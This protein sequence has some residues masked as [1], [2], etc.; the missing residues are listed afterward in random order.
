MTYISWSRESVLYP[1]DYLM[2]ECCTGDIDLAWQENW[3][4]AIYIGQWPIFHGPV[5]L[6][7]ILKTIWWANVIIEILDPCDAKIYLIKSMWVSDLHFMVQCLS[8]I[9]KTIWWMNNVLEILIQC[10]KKIDLK[11]Y[12]SVTYI[13]WSSDFVLYTE[14]YLMDKCHKWDIGSMWCHDLPH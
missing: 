8:Y 2:D 1:K 10:D 14:D 3:P 6:C 13:L 12:L 4:E 7:C 9:L 11:L 5:I